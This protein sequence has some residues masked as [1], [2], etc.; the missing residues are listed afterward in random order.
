MH[1]IPGNVTPTGH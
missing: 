1:R